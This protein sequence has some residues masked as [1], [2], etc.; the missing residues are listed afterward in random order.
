MLVLSFRNGDDPAKYSFDEYYM[1]VVEIKDFN[2]LIENKPCF[3]QELTNSQ[4][5]YEKLIEIVQ[6]IY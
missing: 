6:E 4:Q 3:D 5:V 2:A 1:T